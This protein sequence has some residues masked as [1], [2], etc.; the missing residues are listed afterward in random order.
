MLQRKL[1]W[2]GSKPSSCL[3]TQGPDIPP[4][5][6]R[7][8]QKLVDQSFCFPGIVSSQT[9]DGVE[10]SV[11]AHTAKACGAREQGTTLLHSPTH[12]TR[13]CHGVDSF[14]SW[15]HR[16]NRSLGPRPGTLTIQEPLDSG[17]GQSYQLGLL[18]ENV[19]FILEEA[20]LPTPGSFHGGRPQ[21][22]SPATLLLSCPSASWD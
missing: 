1:A 8:L 11:A 4:E 3:G 19:L 13:H 6:L 15:D 5:I 12:K 14:H 20:N 18:R 22:R 10:E 9:S 2:A 16:R 7:V 17:Q 21:A